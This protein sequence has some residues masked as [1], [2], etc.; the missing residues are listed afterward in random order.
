MF[1]QAAS[2]LNFKPIAFIT[3]TIELKL[4]LPSLDSVRY[5]PSRVSPVASAI[6]V[7]PL[8]RAMSPKAAA[9]ASD[10][11][12]QSS[13]NFLNTK[14]PSSALRA[15]SPI[16]RGTGEGDHYLGLRPFALANGRRCPKGG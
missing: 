1:N 10:L 6:S 7:M 8:A 3:F 16:P 15:P 14:E 5:R 11:L 12:Y 13:F 2:G 9:M 4:G